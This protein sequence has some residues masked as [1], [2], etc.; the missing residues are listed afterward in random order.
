MEKKN[1]RQVKCIKANIDKILIA[2]EEPENIPSH[3]ILCLEGCPGQLEW[4]QFPI[5]L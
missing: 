1:S 5:L 3:H 2:A 4:E